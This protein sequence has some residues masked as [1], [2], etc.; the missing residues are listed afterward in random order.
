MNDEA[1]AGGLCEFQRRDYSRNFIVGQI[2]DL[3][4]PAHLSGLC[5]FQRCDFS[6][7][8]IVVHLCDLGR[9]F[10]SFNGLFRL[11]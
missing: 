5:E 9:F 10:L 7:N 11:R 3:L 2:Y 4:R 8:F 6:R 1:H